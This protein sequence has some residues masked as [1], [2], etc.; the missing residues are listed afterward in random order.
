M[1]ARNIDRLSKFEAIWLGV[2]LGIIVATTLWFSATGTKWLEWRSVVVNWVVSPASAITGVLCVV[3]SAKG[4]LS[5]WTW[6][7]ANSILYGAIAWISGYYGDWLINWFFFVPTQ[8]L[9][10]AAWKG[11]LHNNSTIVRMKSLRLWII[12]LLAM[13][14]LATYEFAHFL[15]SVDS[16]FANALKRN[17][18]VY[19]SFERLSGWPLFG[20]VLDSSTVVLQLAAQF[21]MIA[22]FSEQWIF[23]LLTNVVTIVI[24][25]TVIATDSTSFA[26]SV[27]TLVMWL[28][29][30]VNSSYGAF[31]WGRGS[32]LG[33]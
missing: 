14:G 30:L 10:L 24:W 6:G 19:S 11:N 21:L 9:I 31:N 5:N 32:R 12:P 28:A 7:L 17:S 1:E 29:F 20:P 8:F 23:W 33:R 27:P 22:M 4:K 25:A 13:A 16:F 15:V 26:Y 2:F 3:L 18:F